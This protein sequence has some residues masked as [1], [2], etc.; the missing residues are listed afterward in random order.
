MRKPI[1]IIIP[2]WNNIEMVLACLD[3][4]ARNTVHRYEFI[5]VNNGAKELENYIVGNVKI[6]H[7]GDNLGWMGGIN[8]GLK[9]VNP[10]SEYVL[11][12]NDDTH[13]LPH[14]YDWLDK[15]ENVLINDPEVAAVGP[16]SNVVAG[17]QNM[18]HE[19]LPALVE[20]RFLIG[21]CVLM[22]KSLLNEIGG[23]DESL[24]G[25][26]DFDTSI[27]FRKKGYKLIARRDVFVF[28][29]G[30]VT[31]ERVHGGAD[32][33]M[34]WNSPEMTEATN[35]AIIQKHGFKWF[36]ETIRNQV[37]NYDTMK[38]EYGKGNCLEGIVVGKGVDVGC[39]PSKMDGSIG[40]DLVGK[41][42]TM[43]YGDG[44]KFESD[45]DIKASG[46]DLPF[47]NE[48]LDF[49]V[50]RHNLEHYSNPLKTMKEWNRVLKAGGKVGITTPD[51][52]RT[53]GMRLDPTH[54]HSFCREGIKDIMEST[55][56]KVIEMGGCANNWDFYAIGEK[57]A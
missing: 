23:L 52:E 42:E 47:E 9:Y 4:I 22:R 36:V 18:R 56:F 53:N 45:A 43:T 11:L 13:I 30:F 32:A 8:E 5:V 34:G 12:M 26:D 40:I 21:F 29:H 1:A 16:S 44:S 24:P 57:V 39:G 48:E 3:S 25:G 49:V 15:L 51:D 28:H 37:T 7:T 55:G 46:D 41:G 17:W 35:K 6:V 19:G 38:E 31:G 14:D 33:K 54:K 50:A 2:T 10:E 27:Q 20:T